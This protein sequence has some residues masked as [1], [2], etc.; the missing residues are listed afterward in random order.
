MKTIYS[1]RR[2]WA[3]GEYL[4][5]VDTAQDHCVFFLLVVRRFH[6]A[7]AVGVL[8]RLEPFTIGSF[9]AKRWPGTKLLGE[10]TATV[11]KFR[12]CRESGEV[13]KEVANALWDWLG[14]AY[15]EDLSFLR[16]DG[17]PW[18]ASICHE[19]DAFFKLTDEEKAGLEAV[20][21]SKSLSIDGPDRFPDECY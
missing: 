16:E 6:Q 15:P 14:P 17:S 1:L 2:N 11:H 19:K 10:E 12:L 18:F 3:R 9:E 20:W 8:K 13:L 5:L 21:G 4:S 7:S